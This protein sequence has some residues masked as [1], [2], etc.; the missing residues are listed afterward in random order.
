MSEVVSTCPYC[1]QSATG[2]YCSNCGQNQQLH[3]LEWKYLFADLQRRWLGFDNMFYRTL[4]DMLLAPEEVITSM[5]RGIKVRYMGPVGFFFLMMT[6]LILLYSLLGVD[7]LE[8]TKDVNN[9]FSGTASQK[10]F[11]NQ[12]GQSIFSN[13]KVMA[14]VMMPFY[15]F[16]LWLIF[17]NKK[18]N[19]IETAVLIFYA[20]GLTAT[21]TIVGVLL[22]KFFDVEHVI[23]YMT[24][25]SYSFIAYVC[26][27]FYK[28]NAIWNFIKGFLALAIGTIALMIVGSITGF[29]YLMLNPQLV[30]KLNTVA[31]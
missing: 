31:Q 29:I 26:A 22:Y 8:V 16:G 18:Y 4:R 12:I 5:H 13:F 21:F 6:I 10:E 11:Q 24:P 23:L 20:Q 3:R 9:V 17:K 28:G 19:F 14:F 25:I 7:M 27:R 2:N 30:E 1:E 15:A